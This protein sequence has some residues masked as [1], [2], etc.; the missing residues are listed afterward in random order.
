MGQA[1]D[2]IQGEVFKF[3]LPGGVHGGLQHGHALLQPGEDAAGA[4]EGDGGELLP[5]GGDVVPRDERAHAVP[6][7]EVREAGVPLLDQAGEGVLVLHHG[8]GA[9]VPPVAPAVVDDGG[10]AVAHMVVRRHDEPGVQE[11]DDHVEVPAGVLSEAVDQLDDARGLGGGDVDPPLDLVPLVEGLETDLMQHRCSS[12][13]AARSGAALRCPD[14]KIRCYI[15][16]NMRRPRCQPGLSLKDE[17]EGA[18]TGTAGQGQQR[19]CAVP[20]PAGRPPVF[21]EIARRA[22]LLGRGAWRAAFFFRKGLL[23]EAGWAMLSI[24]SL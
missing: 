21:F 6:V 23:F 16:Y 12:C 11:L 1:V 13:S 22:A 5:V 18:G 9:L 4:A 3:R 15:K 14:G 7:E 8:V 24:K 19:R 2:E 10:P 20:A 17:E